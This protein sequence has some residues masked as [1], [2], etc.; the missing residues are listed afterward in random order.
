MKVFIGVGHGGS[1][2]GAVSHLVEKDVKLVEALDCRDFLRG[3]CAGI[4]RYF[5][6]ERAISSLTR[7]ALSAKFNVANQRRG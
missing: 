1:D 2:P 5:F 4:S 6:W 7:K 3:A